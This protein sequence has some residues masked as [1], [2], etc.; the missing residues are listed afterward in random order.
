MDI[1]LMRAAV[2]LLGL[3]T[4]LAL[5]A[6]VWARHRRAA[7]EEAAMLPFLDDEPAEFSGVKK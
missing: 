6:W 2:T 7:F 1:N 4:F 3:F 5:V